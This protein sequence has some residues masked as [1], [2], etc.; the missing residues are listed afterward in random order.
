M[1][2]SSSIENAKVQLYPQDEKLQENQDMIQTPQILDSFTNLFEAQSTYNTRPLVDTCHILA[3]HR[4][5]LDDTQESVSTKHL[6][7][8]W[9]KNESWKKLN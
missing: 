4:I 7:T 2:V 8:K 6:T 9:H 3:T 1:D 5:L